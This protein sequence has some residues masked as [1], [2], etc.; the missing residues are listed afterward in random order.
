M[1]LRSKYLSNNIPLKSIVSMSKVKLVRAKFKLCSAVN[2]VPEKMPGGNW[3][4]PMAVSQLSGTP[5]RSM[6]MGRC[7]VLSQ[8]TRSQDVG[9]AEPAE[10]MVS[11]QSDRRWAREV[12]VRTAR[13][14][15]PWRA[16]GQFS[17]L[18]IDLA[19]LM[20]VVEH[21][22]LSKSRLPKSK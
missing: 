14:N 6:P 7:V 18:D 19:V 2:P 8:V 5:E 17:S 1:Y 9:H 21:L 13:S 16:W 11:A 22:W 15:R 3:Q 20:H 4:P 10:A 12:Y